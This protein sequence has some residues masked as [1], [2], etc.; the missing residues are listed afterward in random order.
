MEDRHYIDKIVVVEERHTKGRIVARVTDDAGDRSPIAGA[1]VIIHAGTF[2]QAQVEPQGSKKRIRKPDYDLYQTE[3]VFQG[4]TNQNG[5]CVYECAPGIYTI[6]A[7]AFRQIIREEVTVGDDC[8]TELVDMPVHVGFITETY[9]KGDDCELTRCDV[10]I[11][12]QQAFM[13]KA[14]NDIKF[15]KL[16]RFPV[17]YSFSGPLPLM[18]SPDEAVVYADTG[19]QSGLISIKAGITD[20]SGAT[21]SS[22]VAFNVMPKQVQNIGG[23]VA[24]TLRRT[25]TAPTTDLALWAIIRKST[26]AISFNNYNRFMDFVLCGLDI[27]SGGQP[28]VDEFNNLRRRRFLPYNDTDAYRLLKVATEAFLMVNC[29]VVLED[30]VFTEDDLND[31]FSNM[32]LDRSIDTRALNNLWQRYIQSVN[33]TED[34]TLPYLALIREKLR[35]QGRLNVFA[36]EE[37]I[38]LPGG[39]FGLLRTKLTQPCFLELIWSYWHEEGMLVQTMNALSKRFQ[40]VRNRGDYDPLAMVEIDPLRPLN[41]LLWGEIQ[42]E[43]HRLTVVR[44][45][46]EYDHHYG[47]TLYG[48]AVPAI[49]GAD[50]RS[51]FLEAFHNLLHLTSIFFKEDDDTTVIADGF[52][53]LNALREVHFLLAEGAHNQFGDLPSTARQEMLIQQWILARPEFREFL[54]TRI[55]VAYPEPW[56]DRVDAMKKLQGWTDISVREFNALAA[57]GEQILL[58]IRFGAWSTVHDSMQAANWARFWR[59]EIQGYIHSYRAVTGVDMT[60]DLADTKQAAERY[61]QPSIHLRNR[62]G[63]QRQIR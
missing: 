55:M 26:E 34:P 11:A 57:F 27:P 12:G 61:I 23:S 37:S 15:D 39:C 59:P 28:V 46:Y 40:N 62:M 9:V 6:T 63:A 50:S 54:P 16:G 56:M 36:T 48:K 31:L 42:D 49:R 5:E 58:S 4:V 51:K 41:N 21:A 10:V 33:G 30:R 7:S 32:S 25:A 38:D 60:A 8:E 18:K 43:H 14:E 17:N 53:L 44:R 22:R 20:P 1:S 47:L 35:D 13:I 24:V 52:P 2:S 19:G 45:A 3:P 29:G